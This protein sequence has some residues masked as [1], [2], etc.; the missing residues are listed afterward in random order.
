MTATWV[1]PLISALLGASP[2]HM[3]FPVAPESVLGAVSLDQLLPEIVTMARILTT[4]I[5]LI[6]RLGLLKKSI[7]ECGG[8]FPYFPFPRS[9]RISQALSLV[10]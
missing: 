7:G 10:G 9:D 8:Y 6:I 2:L 5:W 3:L 4:T 1:L